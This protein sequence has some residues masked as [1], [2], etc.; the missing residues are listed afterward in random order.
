MN[1]AQVMKILAAVEAKSAQAKAQ[2]AEA[3][4]RRDA[5]VA[6]AERKEAA[7]RAPFAEADIAFD[8]MADDR[9]A[10]AQA[11]E[12]ARLRS[13]A[14]ALEPQIEERRDALRNALREEIA[15]RRLKRR[16]DEEA[17]RRQDGREEARREAIA[18]YRD[19]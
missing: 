5:L 10:G 1:R 13:E 7:S 14:A 9:R 16:L 17:A 3:R 6:E 18:L 2:L 4:R 15:W 12:A 19:R 8:L 11:A